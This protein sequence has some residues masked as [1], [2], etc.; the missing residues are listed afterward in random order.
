MILT[1]GC[2][3]INLTNIADI[4]IGNKQYPSKHKV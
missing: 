4:L 2:E 1:N 3:E